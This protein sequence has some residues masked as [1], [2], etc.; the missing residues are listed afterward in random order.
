VRV[1]GSA[2]NPL[3]PALSHFAGEEIQDFRRR[4]EGRSTWNNSP[5]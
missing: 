2:H 1:T 3:T 5:R 4:T